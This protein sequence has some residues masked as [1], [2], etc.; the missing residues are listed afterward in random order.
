[1]SDSSDEFFDT[2]RNEFLPYIEKATVGLV[3]VQ[4]EEIKHNRT[5]VLYRI[6]EYHFI[7]TAAHGLR[8]VIKNNIPLYVTTN[9]PGIAPIP[10]VRGIF[11]G[12]EVDGRDFTAIR[13]AS[14]EAKQ[15]GFERFVMHNS[16]AVNIEEK[17][18]WYMLAG[19]PREWSFRVLT[20]TNVCSDMLFY[21]CV[22]FTGTHLAKS[23]YDSSVHL[24]LSID[25]QAIE[26]A[27]KESEEL[28]GLHGISGC[29]IWRVAWSDAELQR[30]SPAC[31]VLVGIQHSWNSRRK[32]ID[33][34]RMEHVLDRI[35]Y[36]YPELRPPMSLHYRRGGV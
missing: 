32:Y 1:M 9:T 8:E 15:I 10:I 24:S 16:V 19:Y 13:L 27:T 5:G 21:L 18:G 35:L 17:C 31:L 28:P 33:A 23:S 11:H 12:T 30:V 26:V 3:V 34:T 7:L 20:P 22:P 6:G 2:V 25:Q 36:D 4:G 14:D 29:G